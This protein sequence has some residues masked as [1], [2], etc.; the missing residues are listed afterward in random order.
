MEQAA[1]INDNDTGIVDASDDDYEELGPPDLPPPNSA[2]SSKN[3]QVIVPHIHLH[4]GSVPGISQ[5]LP[6]TFVVQIPEV[7]NQN[8]T[9]KLRAEPPSSS[10]AHGEVIEQGSSDNSEELNTPEKD[11]GCK[12]NRDM[13]SSSPIMIPVQALPSTSHQGSS[14]H[15]L[16]IL[17]LPD[18]FTP[19]SNT[20][21]A[22]PPRSD[23]QLLTQ[24][25]PLTCSPPGA[26]LQSEEVSAEIT[27]Y[28]DNVHQMLSAKSDRNTSQRNTQTLDSPSLHS[29]SYSDYGDLVVNVV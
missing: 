14:G 2:P 16:Y 20:V 8:V 12:T 15:S 23:S 21:V 3:S 26:L 27:S 4:L 24:P 5:G 9:P 7:M 17:S 6:Q 19:P 10:P 1:P 22:V 11:E 28:A 18:N 13:T 25:Y 29:G